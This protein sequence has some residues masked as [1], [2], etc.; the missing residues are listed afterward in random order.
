MTEADFKKT[1]IAY[2]ERSEYPTKKTVL[3]M[4][5][6]AG[7]IF[8]KTEEFTCHKWNFYKEFIYIVVPPS[9]VLDLKEHEVFLSKVCEDVYM[10]DG[11]YE[12]SGILI[13]TGSVETE[14]ISQEI[15]FN[16]IQ[17]Q[18]IA[19]IRAAKYIIWVAMAWFTDSI[20]YDELLKKKAEGLSVE[21]ILDDNARNRNTGF[22]LATAFPIHWV[23]IQSLYP[24]YMHDKFCIIDLQIVLH[25][26]FNWTSAANYNK[27]TISVDR[28]RV[29]AEKFADEFMKLKGLSH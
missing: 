19:E 17:K 21:I 24:N 18:I 7:I 15:L 12:Y 4:L 25:G 23:T 9:V 6:P 20:L 5:R 13:K 1:L 3:D 10:A 2:I 29:T 28:N 22:N 16:D 11:D 27:E 26:T 8:D 14:D